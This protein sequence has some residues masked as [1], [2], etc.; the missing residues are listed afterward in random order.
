[1][2]VV[3]LADAAAFFSKVADEKFRTAAKKGLLSAAKRM[4]T[5]IVI[6]YIPNAKLKQP[7]DR[8]AYKAAWGAGVE[9][10]GAYF[11]NIA[12]HAPFVEYGVRVRAGASKPGKAMIQAIA[13]W[14]VRKGIADPEIASRAGFFIAMKIKSKGIE[15]RAVMEAANKDVLDQVVKEELERELKRLAAS[16]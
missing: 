13:E 1:M 11:D 6:R 14:A 7:V 3:N 4:A 10:D 9:E 5:L 8:G 15:A 12:P 16:L 2:T